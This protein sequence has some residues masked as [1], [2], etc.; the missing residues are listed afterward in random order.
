MDARAAY[1]YAL[2]RIVPRVER[3]ECL[4]AGVILICRECRYLRA[5]T[6]YDQARLLALAPYLDPDTLDGIA[7]HLDLITRLAAGDASAGSIATLSQRER[8]HWLA[9]P[10]STIV[11][12]G[13]VHTGVCSDPDAALDHLFRTLVELPH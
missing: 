10:A 1:E 7:R 2:I 9:A 4:N 12:P 5:R 11:Q 13:A 8:W 6:N 3:G